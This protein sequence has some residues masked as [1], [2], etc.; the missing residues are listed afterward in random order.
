VKSV[1]EDGSIGIEQDSVVSD[2]GELCSVIHD[3]QQ[4]FGGRWFAERFISGREFNVSLLANQGEVEV[5]KIAEIR[6]HP[7]PPGHL[8][9][10]DYAAKWHVESDRYSATE[11][12]FNFADHDSSLLQSLADLSVATWHWMGVSGYA[13]VDVRVDE[14]GSMWILELNVNPSIAPDAGFV[15][16]A[17]QSG[18]CYADMIGRL[19]ED[20]MQRPTHV[21]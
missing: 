4:R 12:S 5:L 19:I 17:A 8:P 16:A 18:V 15:A 3:R 13:R 9:I 20:A 21:K 2:H 14:R 10:V 6:F 1:T 7:L 11:R